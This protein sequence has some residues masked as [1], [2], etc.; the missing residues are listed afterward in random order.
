MTELPILRRK[1]YQAQIQALGPW[2]LSRKIKV[3]RQVFRTGREKI[4]I[5]GKAA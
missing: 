1:K 5:E 3:G 4:V 2:R